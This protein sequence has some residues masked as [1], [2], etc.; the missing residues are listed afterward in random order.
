[1]Q[2]TEQLERLTGQ[3]RAATHLVAVVATLLLAGTAPA[4]TTTHLGGFD[5][6]SG[7]TASNGVFS[8]NS[9]NDPA[10][11]TIDTSE[12]QD[13][14]PIPVFL[15]ATINLEILLDPA[16]DKANGSTIGATF[17]GTA[18][19]LPDI[20]IWDGGDLLL[21]LDVD[22]IKVV[23]AVPGKKNPAASVT[24]GDPTVAQLNVSS[25]L[26]IVGGSQSASLGGLNTP[27]VMQI[28]LARPDPHVT[29]ATLNVGYWNQDV[30][31]GT[32]SGFAGTGVTWDITILSTPEPSSAA[33]L[34][35]SL[36]GLVAMARRRARSR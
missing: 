22:F 16:Y 35:F 26:R 17:L 36:L 7:Y 20:T 10:G 13:A 11:G 8:F 33:L 31:A 32:G 28:F 5:V 29:L 12:D 24:L 9:A 21:S 34:G 27:A 3:R 4:S 19:G 2:F 30:V 1:M 18:D 15:G 23:D 6:G 25:R 14:T